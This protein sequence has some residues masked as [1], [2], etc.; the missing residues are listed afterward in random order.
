MS[1][2]SARPLLVGS[3]KSGLEAEAPFCSPA[4]GWEQEERA[5]EA[6]RYE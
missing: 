3:R 2:F 6:L 4:L 5:V 1:K